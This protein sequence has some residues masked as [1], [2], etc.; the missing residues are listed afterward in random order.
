[1]VI[2]PHYADYVN[3]MLRFYVRNPVINVTAQPDVTNHA[4]VMAVFNRLGR[5][6]RAR[7]CLI[8]QEGYDITERVESYCR[9]TG[10]LPSE[11]WGL[12]TRVTK[13]VARERG[14]AR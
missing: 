1:M 5:K 13:Q 14:L 10:T 12:I 3:H 6:D 2:K 9:D 4:A 8:Y 11:V 7:L